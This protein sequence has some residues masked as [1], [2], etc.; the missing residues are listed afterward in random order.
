MG[1]ADKGY[2]ERATPT[3]NKNTCNSCGLCATV[4]GGEPLVLR[5]KQVEI[6][7]VLQEA[8]VALE[9]EAGQL[10][11]LAAVGGLAVAGVLL[12]L[13]AAATLLLVLAVVLI[14]LAAVLGA[15]ASEALR[16]TESDFPSA[17]FAGHGHDLR[18][19]NDLLSLTRPDAVRDIHH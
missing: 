4:C 11:G 10:A 9:G 5:G 15:G 12:P 16:L 1:K 14:P 3:I 6:D 17:R 18:G 7:P 13:V 2:F 19:N 8:L